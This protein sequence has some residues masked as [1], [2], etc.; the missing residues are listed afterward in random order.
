MLRILGISKKNYFVNKLRV[1]LFCT[2]TVTGTSIFYYRLV[3]LVFAVSTENGT[4][5][6]IGAEGK[7]FTII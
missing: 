2:S 4:F 5:L 6:T 3:K 7:F 1:S